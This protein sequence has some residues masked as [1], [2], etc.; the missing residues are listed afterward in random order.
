MGGGGGGAAA[1]ALLL[2]A[3]KG[4]VLGAVLELNHQVLPREQC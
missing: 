1:E 3:T 2:L 4:R